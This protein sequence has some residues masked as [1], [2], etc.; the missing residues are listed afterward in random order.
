MAFDRW[1]GRPQL[2][3]V[4]VQIKEKRTHIPEWTLPSTL[5]ECCLQMFCPGFYI[6]V[7]LGDCGLDACLGSAR[8]TTTGVPLMLTSVD[9][10]S[11]TDGSGTVYKSGIR[12]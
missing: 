11:R 8:T 9:L 10:P 6:P 12:K 3:V 1:P 2:G 5:W 7:A 4:V